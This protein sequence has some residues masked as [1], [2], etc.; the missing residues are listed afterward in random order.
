M[1]TKKSSSDEA[2]SRKPAPNKKE[3]E[4]KVVPKTE[5]PPTPEIK[6]PEKSEPPVSFA[7]WFS[8]KKFKPH[9]A[10]GMQAYTDTT[11][12]RS[13]ADWDRLFKSY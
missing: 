6:K 13:M 9:W 3:P 7:R 4:A 2:K 11:V 1:S 5:A 10:A 12:R 8:S